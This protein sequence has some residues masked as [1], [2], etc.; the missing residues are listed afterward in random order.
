VTFAASAFAFAPLD[1]ARTVKSTTRRSSKLNAYEPPVPNYC[2]DCGAAEMTLRIPPGDERLR[3]TCSQCGFVE[4]QNPKIVAACVVMTDD[5]RILLAKRAIEPRKGTWG[6]PQGYM[7]HGETS[8][9]AAAREVLEE[10]GAIV[11][12][13]ELKLRAIYNVP[14]S[15][16]LVY[17]ATVSSDQI[18]EQIAKYNPDIG[19]SSKVELVA[20]DAIA[21]KELCFPTV[22]WAIKQCLSH[23][24]ASVSRIQQMTKYYDPEKDVWGEY[25]DEPL[26]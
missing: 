6:I 13:D 10:T 15:V 5:D 4:Y 25:E 19:E 21:D 23:D 7:E 17:T 16:Q 11:N 2:A 20:N 24:N 1:W 26:E 3:A 8:R 14:G 12:D 18:E 9:Q 22:K